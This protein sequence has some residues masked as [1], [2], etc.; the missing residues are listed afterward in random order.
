M[1]ESKSD[2]E[3]KIEEKKLRSNMLRLKQRKDLIN[4]ISIGRCESVIERVAMVLKESQAARNSDIELQWTFWEFYE[5]EI[6]GDGTI[7]KEKLRNL[8]R[9]N[10]LSRWRAKIQNE[11]NLF[12]ADDVVKKRRGKLENEKKCEALETKP[13]YPIYSV[14]VDESGKTSDYLLVG[15][16]W[17]IDHSMFIKSFLE[18]NKWREKN[19]AKKEF[20]FKNLSNGTLNLYKAYFDNFFSL[21]PAIGFKAIIVNKRGHEN[22]Q[23]AIQD[24]T[25]HLIEKG[26]DHENESG[27]APLPRTL[28]VTIDDEEEGADELKL[29]NIKSK[30]KS[31]DN[32]QKKR[33]ILDE[34]V[35]A[36]SEESDY[37]QITD[38]FIASINRM[39]NKNSTSRN[40]KDE[41]AEYILTKIGIDPNNLKNE[42]GDAGKIFW[43]SELKPL[44]Q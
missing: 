1:S 24:L 4:S 2:E 11:F 33:L 44:N 12:Q 3:I 42:L 19:D 15:S 8:T 6:L 29:Q 13:D 20:H 18:M 27:R 39:L 5:S 22:S 30:L 9:H 28:Q 34:F 10:T 7:T 26:I 38:L 21:N 40:H 31:L 14:Y 32:V 23:V 25:Y 36:P 17:I 35:S 43:L 16:L 41:F 37:L